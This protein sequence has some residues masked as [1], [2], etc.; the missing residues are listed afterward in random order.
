MTLATLAPIHRAS[1]VW[2]STVILYTRNRRTVV[3]Y[4]PG[5]VVQIPSNRIT[6]V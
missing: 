6:E 1:I 5:V 2:R 4:K 3:A